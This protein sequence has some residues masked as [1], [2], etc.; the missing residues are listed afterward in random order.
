MPRYLLMSLFF[1]PL[2]LWAVESSLLGVSGLLTTPGTAVLAE[3]ALELQANTDH[4]LAGNPR[5]SGESRNYT[6]TL[7]LAPRV[8]LGGRVRAPNIGTK[9]GGADLAADIKLSIFQSTH[10]GFA[11][12]ALDLAGDANK[13]Q[14]AYGVGSVSYGPVVA[15][16]GY[17]SGKLLD[18]PFGGFSYTPLSFLSLLADYDSQF[19]NVGARMRHSF[20]AGWGVSATVKAYSDSPQKTAFGLSV[21]KDLGQR[22]AYLEDWLVDGSSGLSVLEADAS[23]AVLRAENSAYLE[24]Q[25]DSDAA[26]CQQLGAETL[27]YRQYRYG[28]PVLSSRLDCTT[29][30]AAATESSWLTQWQERA[31]ILNDFSNT[32]AY[33]AEIRLTPDLR[34]FAATEVGIF[35]YSLAL[36]ST[37][38]L[39]LPAGLG[40]YIT[41]ETPVNSTRNFDDPLLFSF[42]KHQSGIREAQVQWAHHLAPGFFGL[43]SYGRSRV[44]AID[45]LS[46]RHDFAWNIGKGNSQIYGSYG[47]FKPRSNPFLP[48]HK[49]AYLGYR[50]FLPNIATSIEADYGRFFYDD[51]GFRAR[52]NR[53]FGDA[54]I[55]LYVKRDNPDDQVA[56]LE[57]SFPLTLRKG[58]SAGPITVVGDPRFQFARGTSFGQSNGRNEIKPLLMVEPQAEYT[59]RTDWL[60]SDRLFPA[61]P[62]EKR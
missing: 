59:L 55:S 15:N 28:L 3:G 62:A 31:S 50:L 58:L 17:G 26:A 39:Q 41:Y 30:K 8:E 1:L 5:S 21:S 9:R 20:E 4:R 53:Y 48:D 51:K 13:T 57:I 35:D 24:R 44:F 36:F 52:V 43:H 7:G 60:D 33:R 19:F 37:A 45:Y 27:H 34:S 22:N 54:I 49:I 40:A 56:G 46:L 32:N 61:Y 11:A 18:G 29:S 14:S 23:Q 2:N 38:R 10:F 12:G 25:A 42:Y 16:I 47:T 6:M